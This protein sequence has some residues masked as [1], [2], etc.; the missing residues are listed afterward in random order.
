MS[1][2]TSRLWS[3]WVSFWF[4]PEETATLAIFRIVYGALVTLWM[5]ALTPNLLVFFSSSGIAQGYPD[6]PGTRWGLLTLSS[7]PFAVYLVFALTLAASVS[8]TLGYRT[9]LAAILVYVG[10]ESFQHRNSM[11]LNSGDSLIRCLALLC[12]MSPSGTSL[13]IDRIRTA[14]GRFWEFP[15]RAPWALR[16]VQVFISTG[17]LMAVWDKLQ[18]APWR[19][20]TAVAYA[21]RILDIQ[22][23][24]L[25]SVVS[26]SHVISEMLTFGTLA[27][28][29][30]I[31]M[32][33]WNRKL[34]PWVLAL[35]V[36]LHLSIE[37]VMTVG[38]F[39]AAMLTSY[40][41]FIPP[42]TASRMVLE[43]RRF[44]RGR[45]G[46]QEVEARAVGVVELVEPRA[47]QDLESAKSSELESTV[48]DRLVVSS[49]EG[50]REANGV[51]VRPPT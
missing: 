26:S 39:S 1:Q 12:A 49:G 21:V 5:L 30:S 41:V 9:R 24:A 43:V 3:T 37:V 23:L 19:D 16:L 2:L 14:P 51:A 48:S 6:A 46:S 42:E 20:G 44:V 47:P 40:L 38:F 17:Y 13:S 18:G 36:S 50:V 7:G 15:A 25:P 32:F 33:V 11:I 34:R 8:L 29:F 45:M 22:R 10:L 4:T 31:G 28:E 27:I 35:G